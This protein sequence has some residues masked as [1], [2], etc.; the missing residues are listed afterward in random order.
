MSPVF[1]PQVAF[2]LCAAALLAMTVPGFVLYRRFL[3]GLRERHPAEWERLGRPTVV[4]YSSQQARRELSRWLADGGFEAL[5]DP[6]FAADVRRYRAYGRVYGA[7]FTGLWI[8]FALVV[9]VRLATG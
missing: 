4:Y 8:L 6:A 9:S 1:V 5:D 3:R 2:A 7:V